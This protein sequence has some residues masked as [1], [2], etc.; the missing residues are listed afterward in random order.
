MNED[1]EH[2][3]HRLCT[4]LREVYQDLKVTSP[5]REAVMKAGF[6]LTLA[7]IQGQRSKIEELAQGVSRPLSDSQC[8]HL[9][10]L[11]IKFDKP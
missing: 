9:Q 11:G 6:S 8:D 10:A 4:L 1:D 5:L 7:F 3:L 2:E